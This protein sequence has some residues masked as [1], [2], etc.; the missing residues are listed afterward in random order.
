MV[1]ACY[2]NNKIKR[3][4]KKRRKAK[5]EEKKQKEA[6][7]SR[8]K[9]RKY[10]QNNKVKNGSFQNYIVIKRCRFKINREKEAKQRSK[11]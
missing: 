8:T 5:N 11:N 9:R 3:K 4:E 6:K 1:K 10:Y 7:Q 2:K